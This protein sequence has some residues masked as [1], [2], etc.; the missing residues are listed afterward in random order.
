MFFNKIFENLPLCPIVLIVLCPVEHSQLGTFP[1]TE[2]SRI[3]LLLAWFV[4]DL[5]GKLSEHWIPHEAPPPS[6][7]IP[8]PPLPHK[9]TSVSLLSPG[10]MWP[11]SILCWGPSRP[12]GNTGT[13]TKESVPPHTGEELSPP[14]GESQGQEG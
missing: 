10:D 2:V 3:T 12:H 9:G 13:A 5:P 8:P 1:L 11:S 6:H 7:F 14:C 4:G